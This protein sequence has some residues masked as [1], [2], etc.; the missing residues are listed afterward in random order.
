MQ[1]ER[2]AAAAGLLVLAGC[3]YTFKGGGSV[4]P[5]D[6]KKVYVPLVENS[7]TET[8]VAT[9]LTDA[10]R[11]EFDRYGTLTVVDSIDEAD[12]ILTARILKVGQATTTTTGGKSDTGLQYDASLT[13]Q[14]EVRRTTGGVLW[15][16]PSLSV[17]KTFGSSRESVVTGSVDF[18]EGTLS[19]SDIGGLD[20]RE[21]ARGQRSESL[22]DLSEQ[23]ARAIYDQAVTPDF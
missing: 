13:V 11:D 7:S 19:S 4:L 20:T 8:G 16:N 1:I 10:L 23:M 21:V 9:L 14:A 18:A 2:S 3:G 12:A 15:R 22:Q 6:V 5:Q 17:T